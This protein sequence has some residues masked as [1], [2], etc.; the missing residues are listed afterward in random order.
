MFLIGLELNPKLLQ[1]RLPLASRITRP[2]G[3]GCPWPWGILL[4]LALEARYRGGH[5]LGYTPA[6]GSP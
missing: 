5:Q 1:G 4:A 6:K 3:W 2:W